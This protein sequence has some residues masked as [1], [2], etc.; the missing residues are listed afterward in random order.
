MNTYIVLDLEW[1]QSPRGKAG[2]VEGIPFEIIEIGAVKLDENFELISKFHALIKPV[3][4]KEIHHKIYELIHKDIREF[5]TKGRDFPDVIQEF[6]DWCYKSKE[7]PTYC[8]WGSM[9]L[10]E[11]QKNMSYHDVDNF[12]PYPLFFYDVQKLFS[13]DRLEDVR[14]RLP[15]E[16]AVRQ[17]DI[18]INGE[19]HRALD[20][21]YY[22][23]LL[24]SKLDFD[25]VATY[26]SL[27][28]YRSPENRDEEIY[29]SFPDYAKYV[30]RGFDSREEAAE[31]KRVKDMLCCKCRRMLK[32]KIRW[33]SDSQKNYYCIA[34]CPEHGLVRGKI[35]IKLN[36]TSKYY[37]VKTMRLVGEEGL[38]EIRLKKE[39]V[40]NKRKKN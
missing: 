40:V 24:L 7:K 11:L 23:A 16:K 34:N 37:V 17:M 19:F 18:V 30:S 8:T 28:L 38:E 20:D 10:N 31:D 6:K 12:F 27:D 39:A 33:F 22:T 26:K 14:E 35:K 21:A 1:N 5:R 29:I 15:L 4:Y 9:D 36:N 3:I 13:L 2:E 25:K 32:K